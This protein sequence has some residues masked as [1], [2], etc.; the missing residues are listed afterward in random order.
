MNRLTSTRGFVFLSSNTQ[1]FIEVSMCAVGT[2]VRAKFLSSNTQDFIE[3]VRWR[4]MFS[5]RNTF[6]SSNTQDFIE[7]V[8]MTPPT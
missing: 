3:V 8:T 1:D 6:L 5:S 7:V 4:R 2:F